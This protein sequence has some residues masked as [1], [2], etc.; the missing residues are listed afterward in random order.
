MGM[1]RA[2]TGARPLC[3]LVGCVFAFF[4]DVVWILSFEYDTAVRLFNATIFL[5]IRALLFRVLVLFF[6]LLFLF[7]S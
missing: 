1:F 7:L 5:N 6:A 3:C 4:L 2:F